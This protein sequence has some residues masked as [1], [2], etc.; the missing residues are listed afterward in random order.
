VSQKGEWPVLPQSLKFSCQLFLFLMVV[1]GC[2]LAEAS[3]PVFSLEAHSATDGAGAAF[4]RSTLSLNVSGTNTLLIVTWHAEF[5]GGGPENWTA[6]NNGIAGTEI[7][8]TNGYSGGAGN[9]R[10]RIYY[11]LNPPPMTWWFT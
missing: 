11:W 9:R 4:N 6:T 8:D 10:F 5:D 3:A 1:F 2:I 7:V